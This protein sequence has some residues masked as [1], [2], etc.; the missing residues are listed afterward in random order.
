M[1]L[2]NLFAGL[3][4]LAMGLTACTKQM[5]VQGEVQDI[6]GKV[7]QLA[8]YRGK[9]LVIN[10]WAAWCGPCAKEI[11]ELNAFYQA[12]KDHNAVVLGVNYDGL[13]AGK[14]HE[15]VKK[16]NI[17]YPILA[18]DPKSALGIQHVPG[19]PATFIVSPEGKLVK[20]LY[21][22]Q[23]QASL[24]KATHLTTEHS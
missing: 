24:E 10:Y 6:D 8:D 16:L 3:T 22:E 17:H 9:W 20:T 2:I 13:T 19:L 1:K 23:S 4:L 11:P 14:L 15:L 7:I 21:G 5:I 12:H 18:T